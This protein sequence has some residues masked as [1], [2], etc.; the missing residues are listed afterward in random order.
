MLAGNPTE[1]EVAAVVAAL[2][3]AA[4]AGVGS[5]AGD[6]GPAEDSWS[7]YWRVIRTA[8]LSPARD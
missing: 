3:T 2:G 7:G 5:G 1:A 6:P 8:A 4:G